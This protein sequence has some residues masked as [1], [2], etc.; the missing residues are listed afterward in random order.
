M[1]KLRS[2]HLHAIGKEKG[3]LKLP[4]SN[5]AMQI[6]ARFIIKLA[7]SDHELAFFQC[8]FQLIAHEA[9][10]RERDA[11]AIGLV[12]I[13]R[14][15]LDIIGGIAIGRGF[16][17]AVQRALNIVKTQHKRRRQHGN[18][19][20]R[21]PPEE[22]ARNCITR[23]GVTKANMVATAAGC[24][25]GKNVVVDQRDEK[26]ALRKAMHIARDALAPEWRMQ[27]AQTLADQARDPAFCAVL[28]AKGG[29]IAGYWP[30]RSEI[31]PLPL[32][33]VLARKG[34]QLALPRIV[35]DTLAFH[36]FEGANTLISG[37]FGTREPTPNALVLTPDL[38]LAP[39]L[40]FDDTHARL[41]YGKGFYD[42]AFT[43]FPKARRAGL[44]FAIQRVT[45]VPSEAHDIILETIWTERG[46]I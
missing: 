44:A 9:G 30:I 23:Y 21:S 5:A 6:L 28:P 4:G 31:N 22:A 37:A 43:Q 41:G 27:A 20:H 38:I 24:K 34:F 7:A 3:A 13:A 14:E 10:H 26:R 1:R 8:D 2:H 29:V 15:A 12:I 17:N 19:R 11:Q 42:R 35:G 16:D 45:H 32:M 36:A 40:A 33:Q 18:A 39:L 46:V 25:G